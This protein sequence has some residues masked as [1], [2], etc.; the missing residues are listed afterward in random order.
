MIP[1]SY[2]QVFVK[3]AKEQ[4][5]E[6]LGV[7]TV[8]DQMNALQG[9]NDEDHKKT[10]LEAIDGFSE[11]KEGFTKMIDTYLE[12]DI[13]AMYGLSKGEVDGFEKSL[14]TNRN[15]KWIPVMSKMMPL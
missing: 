11:A 15:T 2:E 5:K 10:L 9:I 6:V 14:L 1:K 13:Q 7:E 8:E 3:M 4:N 12:Q